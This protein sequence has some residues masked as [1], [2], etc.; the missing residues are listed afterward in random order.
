MNDTI[1]DYPAYRIYK[2]YDGRKFRPGEKI[3]IPYET[4]RYGTLYRFYTLGNTAKTLSR[5]TRIASPRATRP[6]GRTRIR[7]ASTTART[8]KKRFRASTSAT[9]SSSP[10]TA[11]GS[12]P[13]R[14]ATAS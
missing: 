7:F 13:R 3:A 8:S 10:V 12:I 1:A 4:A 14:T 5:P 6:I 2:P 9:R 11:S